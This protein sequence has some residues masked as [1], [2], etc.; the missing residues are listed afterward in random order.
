MTKLFL[1][2]EFTALVKNAELISLC[3]YADDAAYFYAEFNDYNRQELS[4]WHQEHVIKNL[5]FEWQD[6]FTESKGHIT[7]IKG[8]K[9]LVVASLV[10]WLSHLDQIEIWGDVLAYDWVLFCNLFGGA[11]NIPKNIFYI[12]FDLAT[13]AK[14][15]NR[16]PDFSRYAMAEKEMNGQHN[17]LEDCRV[18]KICWEK[19]NS[20]Q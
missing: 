18:L 6:S 7:R 3:M 11:L 8:N 13:L 16:D 2:C 14:L 1:D 5:L 4:T 12:P 10:Q 9:E 17:A 20:I 15:K 19:I